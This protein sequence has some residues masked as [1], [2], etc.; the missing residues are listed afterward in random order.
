ME[1]KGYEVPKQEFAREAI[2][3]AVELMRTEVINAK[4]KLAAARTVL[5][6]TMAK[7]VQQSEVSI[8]R[9]EDFLASVLTAEQ[10]AKD[11]V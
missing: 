3:T 1:K 11:S 9:A 8:K 2:E 7:P 6:W 5:E 10:K 4:D